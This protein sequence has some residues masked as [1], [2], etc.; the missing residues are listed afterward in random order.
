M[1]RESTL[2]DREQMLSLPPTENNGP[3]TVQTH[4]AIPQILI[5][6]LAP[7]MRNE[8]TKSFT[9][10]KDSIDYLNQFKDPASLIEDEQVFKIIIF[11]F[12][13]SNVLGKRVYLN[14][15]EI[16]TFQD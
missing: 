9:S 2:I 8:E 3:L 7:N 10:I 15:R 1:I 14:S 16:V 13:S 4:T 5:L 12:N 6:L 11:K